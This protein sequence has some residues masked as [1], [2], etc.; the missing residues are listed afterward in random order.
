ME[1]QEKRKA[2]RTEMRSYLLKGAESEEEKV[3]RDEG[4]PQVE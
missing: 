4:Y 2:A 1:A 3:R